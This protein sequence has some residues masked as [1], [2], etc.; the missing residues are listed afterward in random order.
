MLD[1]SRNTR[2]QVAT[3]RVDIQE[4]IQQCIQDLAYNQHFS[5]IHFE[6]TIRGEALNSDPFRLKIIFLN[7]ISNA[8]KYQ[9]TSRENAYLNIQI[10]VKAEQAL[11]RFEDNGIGIDEKHVP[12][13][14]D[15]FF[16]A[17]QRS[18]GSGLG[19]Y[20]VKQTVERLGGRFSWKAGWDTERALP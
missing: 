3:E 4:I 20:I 5:R 9:H 18:E 14:F 8:I 11:I 6:T 13:I 10:E 19:M 15:M 17:S 7:I 16:R 12:Q 2:T 1:F